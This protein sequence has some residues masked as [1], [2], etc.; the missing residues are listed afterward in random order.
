MKFIFKA[1]TPENTIEGGTVEASDKDS[2]IRHLQQKG[3][4]PLEVRVAGSKFTFAKRIEEATT[5]VSTKDLLLFFREFSTLVS[6]KV[7]IAPALKTIYEQ[8]ENPTMRAITKSLS[9]DIEDGLSISESFAKHPKVFTPLMINMIKAGEVSGNLQGAIEYVTRT[10]EQNY[11]LTAKVRGALMYPAFVISV[12]GVIGFLTITWI[13][14]KLTGV[15][16]EL[17]VDIPWYT[18]AMIALGDFMQ[19]YWWVVLV[20]FAGL[21][22]AFIYYLRTPEGT[23]E[24]D[25]IKLKIPILGDLFRYVYLTRMTENLSVLVAGGIPIVQSLIIISEVVSNGVYKNILLEAAREVKVG[26]EINTTF[27]KYEAIPPMVARMIKVGEETGRLSSVLE[28]LAEFYRNEVDQITRNLSALIEPVLIVFLG[29][30][31][32]VLVV[33][34]LL[35]IYN[36]AGQL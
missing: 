31:V 23:K 28:D 9:A 14:P 15:I 6:A 7:P 24:F 17:D 29:V 21:V 19:A 20:V 2:A 16:R 26:G 12:A 35:P 25:R 18:K 36:I 13:L 10:T 3:Y 4:T 27:F 1:R 11:L 8:T 33:S 32:G 22:I 30:G 5:R 34:V